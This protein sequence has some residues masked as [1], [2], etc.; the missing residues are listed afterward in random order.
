MALEPR[1]KARWQHWRTA[2]VVLAATTAAFVFP[3]PSAAG[4][5]TAEASGDIPTDS[6]S[7][8]KAWPHDR[9]AFTEG[10]VF[11]HGMLIEST[12]L[13]GHSTLRKVDLKT[14]HVRQEVRLADEYFGEGIAVVGRKIYQLTWQNHRGFVYDVDTLEAE[15]EFQFTG[16]GW[17]LATDGRSLIMS[18]GTNRIRFI[19]P[20]TFQVTRTID[21]LAHGQ[22]VKMLNELEYV[23]GEL[24]ANVWQTEFVIRI[25]PATGRVLGSIDFVGI[26]PK[27]DRAADTDVMNGIAYDAEDDRLF[28]T[29]KNWPELF[30][31]K[32]KPK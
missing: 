6:Y 14:G 10:L 24:Y 30:E 31:V 1:A 7:L 32:V 12:G 26:L 22:P 11:W 5:D 23:K 28:V 13:Y 21:V 29:G 9:G 2:A 3:R 19:D 8:V 25:D 17:G 18:D 20:V 4:T 15:G 27:A 16:E